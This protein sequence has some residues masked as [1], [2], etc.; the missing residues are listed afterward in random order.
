MPSQV[1]SGAR[2]RFKVNGQKIAYAG[3]V[4]G[5]EAVDHEPVEV[6][7]LIEV[8]EHVPVGY[9]ASLNANVFRVVNRSLKNL[10]IFPIESNILASGVLEASIEDSQT[11]QTTALFQGVRATTKSFDISARGLVSE[12]VAFVAIRTM[13]ELE[14]GA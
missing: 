3:G 1:I 9:R 11:N 12:N 13:D 6:L 10:G 7:D 5:E 4:S 8:L 2:A 14:I